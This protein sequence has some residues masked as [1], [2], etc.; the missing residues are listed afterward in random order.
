M[1]AA[2]ALGEPLP[3]PEPAPG[4]ANCRGWACRRDIARKAGD[5]TRVS[6]CNVMIRRCTH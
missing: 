2:P 3:E 4:C 6:D 1:E 5:L